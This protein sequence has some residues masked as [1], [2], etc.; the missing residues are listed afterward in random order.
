[1]RDRE[2]LLMS[3]V[4][5]AFKSSGL[6]NEAVRQQ[7]G[8]RVSSLLYAKNGPS[9]YVMNKVLSVFRLKLSIVPMEKWED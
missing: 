2:R 7:C 9:I 3:T 5:Q 4:R 1:M 6:S 8:S